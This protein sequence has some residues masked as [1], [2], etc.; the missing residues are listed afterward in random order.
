MIYI[1]WIMFNFSEDKAKSPSNP[2]ILFLITVL[3]I[4]T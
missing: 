4:T 2:P 1:V 3:L